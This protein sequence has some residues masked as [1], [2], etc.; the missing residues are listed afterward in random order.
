[1]IGNNIICP[2]CR[3]RHFR[4]VFKRPQGWNVQL[5]LYKGKRAV[6]SCFCQKAMFLICEKC[7]Y[8]FHPIDFGR[9]YE[10]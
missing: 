1:M 7:G 8:R 6:N 5:L 10:K 9:Y 4:A 3:N 2:K